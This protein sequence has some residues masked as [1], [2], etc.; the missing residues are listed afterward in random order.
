MTINFDNSEEPPST[1]T[2][3]A[4]EVFQD[5]AIMDERDWLP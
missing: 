5:L 3:L 1:F 2:T 4:S